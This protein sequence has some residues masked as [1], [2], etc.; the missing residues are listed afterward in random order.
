MPAAAIANHSDAKRFAYR[1]GR[2]G[3]VRS[4]TCELSRAMEKVSSY[5]PQANWGGQ[6]L[7]KYCVH[8]FQM[9]TAKAIHILGP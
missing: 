6:L 4:Y 8:T 1:V 3:C 2:E 5:R 9:A 7:Y